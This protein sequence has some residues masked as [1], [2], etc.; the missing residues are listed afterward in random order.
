[1]FLGKFR[2]K[3]CSRQSMVRRVWGDG[4]A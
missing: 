3:E 4:A 1:L 2:P